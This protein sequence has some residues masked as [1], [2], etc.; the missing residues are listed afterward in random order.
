VYLEDMFVEYNFDLHHRKAP[1]V[2]DNM[3]NSQI[4]CACTKYKENFSLSTVL[5]Y[6]KKVDVSL[7]AFAIY[8]K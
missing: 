3:I 2:Q 8:N 1:R 5:N 4:S 7:T 6:S